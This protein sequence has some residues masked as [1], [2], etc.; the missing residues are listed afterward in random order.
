VGLDINAVK[1]AF[2]EF[3]DEGIYNA[4]QINFVNK[5]IDYLMDIG[6]LAMPHIF[7]APF[8]DYHGENAYGFFD[9]GKVVELF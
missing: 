3:L 2:S 6:V 5:T 4:G 1:E 8:A 9:E 7:E